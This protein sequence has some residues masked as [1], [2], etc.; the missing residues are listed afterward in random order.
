MEIGQGIHQARRQLTDSAYAH[1]CHCRAELAPLI[2]LPDAT[3]EQARLYKSTG[4]PI[5]V[6]RAELAPLIALPDATAEQAWLYE[7]HRAFVERSLL[8]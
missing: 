1:S 8:R 4:A 3:A 6:R 5:F 7:I 2:A